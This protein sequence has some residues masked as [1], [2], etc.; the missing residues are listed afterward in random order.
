MHGD[1]VLLHRLEQRRLRFRRRAVD[2]VGEDDVRE[3]RA[4]REHHLPAT[5]GRVFLHQVGAGDV[6]RHQVRRELDTRELQVEHAGHRVN[7]QRLGQT[8]G[9]DDQAVAT[10]K[11]RHQHL[12]DDLVLTDDD[13]LQ[14]GDDLLAAAVHAVGKRDVVRRRRSTTWVT[15]VAIRFIIP[16][17]STPESELPTPK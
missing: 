11:Q 13:L 7:E 12:R 6:R 10:D 3:D 1:A 5:G 14:L 15:S 16:L 2:F 17:N 4:G 8:R 9:A